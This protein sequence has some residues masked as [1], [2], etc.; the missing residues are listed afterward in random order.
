M[1]IIE[2]DF[3]L[4]DKLTVARELLGQVLVMESPEG[5]IKG[6]I[7]ETEA[8]IGPKD[9]AA[10]SY[11]HKG[12]GGSREAVQYGP[13]GHA[14]VYLIYGMYYC[15]NIVTREAGFPEMALIRAV[16]PLEGIELMRRRRRQEKLTALCG[17]PGKLCQAFG[18]DK[19]FFGAD[20]CRPPFYVEWG[21]GL[22]PED[23]IAATPRIN[24]DYAG[25]ARDYP[26]RFILADSPFLSV[27]EKK[28]KGGRG[29][30][31]AKEK[32]QE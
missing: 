30:I 7:V 10:H 12:R 3:Y 2:R 1:T 18:I 31:A 6:R 9:A 24:I 32:R 26:W 5:V 22:G 17:G 16:E 20:M 19:T 25:E 13:G 11:K 29:W 4:R 21:E 15:A 14:Y 23:R 28:G 8:Y 27:R